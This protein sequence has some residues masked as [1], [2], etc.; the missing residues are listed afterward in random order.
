MKKLIL[1]IVAA[2][3]FCFSSNGQEA[4]ASKGDEVSTL[5]GKHLCNINT[6]TDFI[7]MKKR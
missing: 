1:M 6:Y 3:S 4:D 7:L 5:R 2:M